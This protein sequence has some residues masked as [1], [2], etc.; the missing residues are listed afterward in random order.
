M[1]ELAGAEQPGAAKSEASSERLAQPQ[2]AK[3]FTVRQ[4][5]LALASAGFYQGPVDGKAGPKTLRAIREFQQAQGL[6]VDGIV[7]SSTRQALAK[8]LEEPQE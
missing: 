2:A 7:G 8:Y 1:E 6:K 5:Q 4:T 3:R